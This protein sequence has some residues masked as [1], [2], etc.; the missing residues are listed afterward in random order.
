VGWLSIGIAKAAAIKFVFHGDSSSEQSLGANLC[1]KFLYSLISSLQD[2]WIN[3]QDNGLQF[4]EAMRS[5][6]AVPQLHQ[7]GG[8]HAYMPFN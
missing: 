2:M 4:S 1:A 7:E 3:R 5:G 8:N 6:E